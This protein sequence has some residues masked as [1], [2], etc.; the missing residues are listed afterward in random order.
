MDKD[1][2]LDLDS[3]NQAQGVDEIDFSN[4]DAAKEE[5]Q[6]LFDEHSKITDKNKQLYS[7]AKKAEGFELVDGK[8]VKPAPKE[9]EPKVDKKPPKE[10]LQ[11]DELDYGQLAFH[12][13]KPDVLKIESEE[14]VEFLQNTI[15]ETGKSQAAILSSK[16]FQAELQERITARASANA[17]P[18]AKNRSG[19][20]VI[21]DVDVAVAKYKETGELPKDFATRN[22]VVD[23]ITK[24][25]S[26][27]MF[28][29]P[30]VVGPRG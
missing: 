30:S 2:E 15:K 10:S 21:T 19:Q 13:T 5:Y 3:T 27:E 25:E 20:T 6:K 4:T 14:D 7:R 29:G 24:E 1:N 28:S 23:A 22:K 26:G 12:N 18:K 8:W 16:W 11:P 17:V 9:P